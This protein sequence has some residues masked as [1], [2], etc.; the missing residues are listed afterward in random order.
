[1]NIALITAKGSQTH[2]KD[3]NL[4]LIAGKPSVAY[5]IEAAISSTSIDKVFLSTESQG[6]ADVGRKFGAKVIERPESLAQHDTNHGDVI[7]HAHQQIK[8]QVGAYTNLVVLLGNTVMTRPQDIS[9]CLDL[10]SSDDAA[11]SCMTVWEAQD[12]HPLRAMVESPDG[13][14]QSYLPNESPDTNRQSYPKVFFYDQGPWVV[15]ARTLEFF[16]SGRFEDEARG[17]GPWWWMGERTLLA[18]RDWV[19]GRDTHGELDLSI[20]EWWLKYHSEDHSLY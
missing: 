11:T 17:P 8:R 9:K 19:T 5:S 3:K 16:S 10:L 7:L 20:A 14:L 4:K 13:Y 1:M 15:R 12:D 2:L 18:R 6:I